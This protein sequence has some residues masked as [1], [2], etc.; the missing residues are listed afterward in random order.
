MICSCPLGRYLVV[1]LL[2]NTTCLFLAF[3]G[4]PYCYPLWLHWF[5]VQ[6]T[7]YKNFPL[8][9]PPQHFLLS[10]FEIIAILT[11]MGSIS[12]WFWFSWGLAML[13]TFAYICSAICISSFYELP[14]CCH[15]FCCWVY[16]VADVINLLKYSGCHLC[17]VCNFQTYFF[18]NSIGCLFTL[19]IFYF[20]FLLRVPIF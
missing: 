2:D 7:V 3:W 13:S 8:P 12:L 10:F 9:H 1:V 16:W 5:P 4:T 15:C 14:F 19:F 17:Q 6:P 20:L 11:W 18:L